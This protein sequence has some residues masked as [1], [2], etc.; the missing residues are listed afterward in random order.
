MAKLTQLRL[1]EKVEKEREQH[2]ALTYQQAKSHL[3]AQQ[4]KLSGIERYRLDYLQLIRQKAG[5]GMG[6]NTMV[7]HQQFVAQLDKACEQ[8][9]QVINQAVLVSDQR[10]RQWLAQQQKLKAVQHL[11]EKNMQAQRVREN[12]LEQKMFDEIANQRVARRM[13]NPST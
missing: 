3:L 2:L 5:S 6:A 13:L 1:L 10:K 12:K 9:I 11:I 4:Q 7:Q 8:Q